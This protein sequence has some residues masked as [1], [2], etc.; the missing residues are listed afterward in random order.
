MR[1]SFLTSGVRSPGTTRDLRRV[2]EVRQLRWVRLGRDLGQD[3]LFVTPVTGPNS[4]TSPLMDAREVQLRSWTATAMESMPAVMASPRA[5]IAQA[6]ALS[7]W[8]RSA[9]RVLAS[10]TWD[11]WY[12][13]WP[14]YSW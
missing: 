12:M 10:V 1:V 5:S 3:P 14:E 13:A 11:R 9:S 7:M 2:S 4:A 6:L 8:L